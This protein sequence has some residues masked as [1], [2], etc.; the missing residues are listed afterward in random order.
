MAR[1]WP[2]IRTCGKQVHWVDTAPLVYY[3][4]SIDCYVDKHKKEVV[5]MATADDLLVSISKDADL[6]TWS[7]KNKTMHGRVKLPG[8]AHS[9][10]I[11]S[12]RIFLGMESGSVLVFLILGKGDIVQQKVHTVL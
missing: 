1:F 3:H 5:A 8:Q 4:D 11:H 6:I 7:M 2:I 9:L 10:C 12:S